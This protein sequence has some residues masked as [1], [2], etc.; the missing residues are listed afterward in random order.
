MAKTTAAAAAAAAAAADKR[1]RRER[2]EC[3]NERAPPLIRGRPVSARE[4][5]PRRVF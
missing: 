2:G 1:V 3:R 5:S 4:R